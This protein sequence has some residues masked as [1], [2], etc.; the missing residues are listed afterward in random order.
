MARVAPQDVLVAGPVDPRLVG[1]VPTKLA[2]DAPVSRR[3]RT[4][5]PP[6]SPMAQESNA[7]RSREQTSTTMTPSDEG[8]AGFL[9]PGFAGQDLRPKTASAQTPRAINSCGA[10]AEDGSLLPV[11]P[12]TSLAEF[13]WKRKGNT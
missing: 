6:P 3:A 1:P 2:G 4:P 10:V 12:E 5:P 13:C 8:N 11:W 7:A 9:L